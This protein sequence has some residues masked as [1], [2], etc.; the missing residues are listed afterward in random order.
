MNRWTYPN[1]IHPFLVGDYRGNHYKTT[2]KRMPPI[3]RHPF[4]KDLRLYGDC[5]YVLHCL[6]MSRGNPII[7]DI[8]YGSYGTYGFD[9]LAADGACLAGMLIWLL[10]LLR[11]V[12]LS[13]GRF[14]ER[15]AEFS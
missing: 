9:H 11:I 4:F 3:R 10:L 8:I 15:M 1:L 6:H 13:Y 5:G 2:Q 14:P 12:I 7:S